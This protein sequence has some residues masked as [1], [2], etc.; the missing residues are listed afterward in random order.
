[1]VT[2][3]RMYKRTKAYRLYSFLEANALYGEKFYLD[4]KHNLSKYT[5]DRDVRDCLRAKVWIGNNKP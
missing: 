2:L 1:L 4:P 3:E 5:Y